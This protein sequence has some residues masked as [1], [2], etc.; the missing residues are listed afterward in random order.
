MGFELDLD[1]D[2]GNF[3]LFYDFINFLYLEIVN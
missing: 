3:V 1:L 2:G